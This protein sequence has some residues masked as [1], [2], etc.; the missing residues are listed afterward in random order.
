MSNEHYRFDFQVAFSTSTG[1]PTERCSKLKF[2]WIGSIKFSQ[3]LWL[4]SPILLAT[5]DWVKRFSIPEQVASSTPT[6]TLT[7]RF[8]YSWT[9]CLFHE[10]W[11]SHGEVFTNYCAQFQCYLGRLRST[12]YLNSNCGSM[13][14]ICR[15]M[16]G[17]CR[18]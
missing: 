7:E 2:D 9:G 18:T 16:I 3:T 15:S 4:I 13:I 8:F 12:G 6:G 17:I 11:Y 14:S 5:W 10:H 1:P